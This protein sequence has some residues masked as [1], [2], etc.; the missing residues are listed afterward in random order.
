M[1]T[2]FSALPALI[3][4]GCGK[5]GGALLRG[6]QKDPHYK[7]LSIIDPNKPSF[8][9]DHCLHYTD[10]HDPAIWSNTVDIVLL[11]VK[12]KMLDILCK[13]LA[14]KI[15]P[16][17]LVVTVAAGWTLEDYATC[18]GPQHPVIRTIPNTPAAIG[19]GIT[20]YIG[21]ASASQGHLDWVQNA[22]ATVGETVALSHEDQM[23]AVTALSSSGPAYIFLL[24]EVLSAAGISLG[25][26]I[27]MAQKLAREMV[28]G[29]AALL[30]HYQDVSPEILRQQV[31]SPNGT[32]HAA[33]TSLQK[34]GQLQ[35]LFDI[36]L[37]AAVIR[38]QAMRTET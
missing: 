15:E 34:D 5:M 33:I 8:L 12:P 28:I 36:A 18:F 10:I 27:D 23:D 22:F 35:K 38:A 2:Q 17:T 1:K 11:A 6:W 20:A 3:M 16:Q 37:K 24:T 14:A 4:I 31:T 9:P 19:K 13:E 25:L 29:S 26:S 32:T 30:D 21:N 7:S